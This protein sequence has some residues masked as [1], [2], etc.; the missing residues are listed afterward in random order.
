MKYYVYI[1]DSK[2]EM[3]YPQVPH[4][5]NKKLTTKFGL[6]LKVIAAKKKGESVHEA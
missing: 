3:L 1:S 6:D 5:I 4:E 2:L